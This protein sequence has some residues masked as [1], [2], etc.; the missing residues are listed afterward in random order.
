VATDVDRNGV[1]DDR[2]GFIDDLNGFDFANSEDVDGDGDYDD[3]GDVSDSDPFDDF[4]HGTHVAG[5]IA[6]VA[7][8]GIGVAA[9]RRARG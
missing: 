5:T 3:P 4:G 7:N 6:A 2:N 8:N 1:D 9:W